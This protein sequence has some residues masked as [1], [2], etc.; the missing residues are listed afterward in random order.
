[1]STASEYVHGHHQSVLRSHAWRTAENSAAYLLPHL[2]PEMDVLDVGCGPGTITVDLASRVPGGR[3]MGV[4][5]SAEVLSRAADLAVAQG[6]DNVE[7]E[8][9]DATALPYSAESFDVVHAHQ[10]LQHLSDPV[11]ALREMRRV[12]RPGGI[13]AVRDAD[14]GGMRWFPDDEGLERWR[15]L[16]L[17]LTS[18]HHPDAGRKLLSWGLEAGFRTVTPSASVWCFADAE[19]RSWW[20]GTWA[21]RVEHSSFAT[22]AVDGGHATPDELADVARAWRDWASLDDAW[23]VVVHGE[24]LARP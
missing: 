20:A 22:H 19:S 6:V 24:L 1:M 7:L 8:Q 16:Y 23:F 11:A 4:D 10:L 9:A 17:A 18:H 13:L 12:L 15:D 3:V 14:Y 5:T 2:R 21:E